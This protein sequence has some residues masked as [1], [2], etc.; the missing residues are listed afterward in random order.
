MDKLHSLSEFI[1]DQTRKEE[2][3]EDIMLQLLDK[4]K[5]IAQ[6]H[7]KIKNE[8]ELIQQTSR[9]DLIELL[10]KEGLEDLSIEGCESPYID[11]A[12]SQ[13]RKLRNPID[14]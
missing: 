14:D 7:R 13:F 12:Y 9:L 5:E 11:L 10:F 1:T 6:E 2:I 8:L 3:S 4:V